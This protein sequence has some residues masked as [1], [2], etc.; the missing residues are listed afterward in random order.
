MGAL[1]RLHGQGLLRAGAGFVGAYD[2]FESSLVH[3]YEPARRTLASYPATD[4]L[5]RL[6]EDSGNTLRDFYPD[7]AGDLDT[8][9]IAAWLAGEGAA[10]AYVH[11]VYDQK[12]GV[13]ITQTTNTQQPLY[14]VSIQNSRPGVRPDGVDDRLIDTAPTLNQPFSVVCGMKVND[15]LNFDNHIRNV[16]D[17]SINVRNNNNAG[18]LIFI[19]A[20]VSGNAAFGAAGTFRILWLAFNGASSQWEVNANG[21]TVD[22]YGTNAFDGV[23]LGEAARDWGFYIITNGGID[24]N[25]RTAINNYWAVY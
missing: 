7:A 21:A 1:K 11:T 10:N 17:T 22:N 8:A 6:R 24:T 19:T 14:V 2:A 12:G 9:A 18:G 4:P 3:V 13:D 15:F 25:L 16:A 23:Y 20:G 5:V